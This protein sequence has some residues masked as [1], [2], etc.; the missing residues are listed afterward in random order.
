[1]SS[2]LSTRDRR[3]RLAIKIALWGGLGLLVATA[4][5]TATV[6]TVFWYYGR[7]KNLPSINSV[8]DYHPKQ[9]TVLLDKKGERIAEIFS[10]RRS[11]VAYEDVPQLQFT[12]LPLVED[13]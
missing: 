3:K 2:S 12:F 8:G 9:V 7:D 4:L 5:V 6:A 1:M 11:Y 10:E 13:R